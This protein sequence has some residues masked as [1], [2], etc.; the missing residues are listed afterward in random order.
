MTRLGRRDDARMMIRIEGT[1]L[2]GRNCGPC[3]DFPDGHRNIHVEFKGVGDSKTE[4]AMLEA[5][6]APVHVLEERSTRGSL[7]KLRP[8][9]AALIENEP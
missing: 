4:F 2:P 5:I 7:D 6:E 8:A 3:P 9:Y 1:E